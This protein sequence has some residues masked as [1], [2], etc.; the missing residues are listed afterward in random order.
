M[1][2]ERQVERMAHNDGVFMTGTRKK[3]LYECQVRLS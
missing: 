2:A 1:E 3:A